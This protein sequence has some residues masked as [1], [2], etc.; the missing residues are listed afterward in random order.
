MVLSDELLRKTPA[1]SSIDK[2]VP[3]TGTA[4]LRKPVVF[5]STDRPAARATGSLGTLAGEKRFRNGVAISAKTSPQEVLSSL[6][7]PRGEG[8]DPTPVIRFFPNTLL[9]CSSCK[10]V[11]QPLQRSETSTPRF[12]LKP[13][14]A[15]FVEYQPLRVIP[16]EQLLIFARPCS[17]PH[18]H[19]LT[20]CASS[21]S[22]A[23]IETCGINPSSH[24]R[25]LKSSILL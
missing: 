25:A 18:P 15:L 17:K 23:R 14:G 21:E 24:A 11:M 4:D 19:P 8:V 16:I 10:P 2:L 7:G 5:R 1:G 3:L 20:R 9:V 13:H 12:L 22:S 6:P